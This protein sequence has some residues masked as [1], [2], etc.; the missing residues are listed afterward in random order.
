MIRITLSITIIPPSQGG[1][2]R[3]P[4]SAQPGPSV[5]VPDLAKGGHYLAMYTIADLQRILGLTRRQVRERL[6][7][8]A[9]VDGLLD[10]QVR[11]GPRGRKEYSV[12]VLEMLR[13]LDALAGN[14]G[15]PLRQAAQEVAAK[16]KENGQGKR[17]DDVDDVDGNRVQLNGQVATGELEA[18]RAQ[19]ELLKHE[20]ERLWAQVEQLTKMLA[21]AQERLAL[22][23]PRR[24]WWA[25]LVPWRQPAPQ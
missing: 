20:N 19:V 13:D 1:K 25:R 7:A 4:L 3:E 24:P 12:A 17:K 23:A 16:I 8:L 6:A 11:K 2:H 21:E 9:A 10:G 18:L 22:P 14:L 15:L 5:L